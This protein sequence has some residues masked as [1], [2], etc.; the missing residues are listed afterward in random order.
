MM[1][2]R[3]RRRGGTACVNP[4]D[5]RGT[6]GGTLDC[7]TGCPHLRFRPLQRNDPSSITSFFFC[8]LVGTVCRA[9]TGDLL[10]GS[11]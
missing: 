3:G 5:A 11:F 1:G 7:D 9:L 4:T 8:L 10:V 2:V 6:A